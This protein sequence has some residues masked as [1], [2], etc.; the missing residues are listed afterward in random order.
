MFGCRNSL[1]FAVKSVLLYHKFRAILL[2]ALIVLFNTGVLLKVCESPTKR[3]NVNPGYNRLPL[4]VWSAIVMF[5]GR[6]G[7]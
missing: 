4:T 6:T 2:W 1:L 7:G 5:L 3:R